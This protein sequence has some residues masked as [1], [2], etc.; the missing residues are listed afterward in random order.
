MWLAAKTASEMTW[1][2]SGGALKLYSDQT[3][4]KMYCI[5]LWCVTLAQQVDV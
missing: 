2:M 1:I 5:V 4:M 3:T